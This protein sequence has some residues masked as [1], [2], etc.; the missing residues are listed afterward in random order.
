MGNE[1][2]SSKLNLSKLI[3]AVSRWVYFYV[4]LR[5]L[6]RVVMFFYVKSYTLFSAS[7]YGGDYAEI[8]RISVVLPGSVNG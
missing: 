6:D 4:S 1:D 7:I 3:Q 2:R 5:S 8:A